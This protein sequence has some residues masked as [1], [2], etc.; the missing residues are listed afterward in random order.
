MAQQSVLPEDE[1]T[2]KAEAIRLLAKGLVIA[3]GIGEIICV[4][5][6]LF[7]PLFPVLFLTLVFA[8]TTS[9]GLISYWLVRAGKVK[10]AGYCFVLG[11]LLDSAIITPLFGGFAGPMAITYLFSILAAGQAA[12]WSIRSGDGYSGFGPRRQADVLIPYIH[13]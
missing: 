13:N 8:A 1:K 12:N 11:L 4:V 10:A 5:F 2:R 9:V 3:L 6:W 7:N